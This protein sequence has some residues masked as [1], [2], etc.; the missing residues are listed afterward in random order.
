[1]KTLNEVR[2]SKLERSILACIINSYGSGCHP[3]ADESTLNGFAFSYVKTLVRKAR[4][5]PTSNTPRKSRPLSS[6]SK[7]SL[8]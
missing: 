1:M 5:A 6:L 2:L 8:I 3:C 7:P 4:P